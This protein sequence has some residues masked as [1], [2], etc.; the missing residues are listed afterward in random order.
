MTVRYGPG[1]CGEA[2]GVCEVRWR[3][4]EKMCGRWMKEGAQ[5]AMEPGE[6]VK[7]KVGGD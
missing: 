6:D 5:G 2:S 3:R 4:A 1:S 7:M